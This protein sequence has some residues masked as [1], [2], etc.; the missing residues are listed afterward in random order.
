[1]FPQLKKLYQR[2]YYDK[3]Y[4]IGA[5]CFS[6]FLIELPLLIAMP[7]LVVTVIFFMAGVT[8]SA[9]VWAN[10][11]G[12]L[13]CD[14]SCASGIGYILSSFAD[15]LEGKFKICGVILILHLSG[16]YSGE[17]HRGTSVAVW[18]TFHQEQPN[19]SLFL[20]AQIYQL[21]LLCS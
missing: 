7:L 11:W 19:P 5:A 21:V 16:K 6:E 10:M 20:L 14:I 8:P 1:M 17:S 3:A 2:E 12:S 18:R 4:G 13:F 15:S 9:A